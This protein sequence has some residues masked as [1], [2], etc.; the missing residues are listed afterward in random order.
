[1]KI[2]LIIITIFFVG[3]FGALALNKD[4][5][6]TQ[7]TFPQ[8][9]EGDR[10]NFVNSLNAFDKFAELTTLKNNEP[11]TLSKEQNQEALLKIEEGLNLS[12]KIDDS[13]LEY[14]SPDLKYYYREKYIKGSEIYYEGL[15]SNTGDINS[16]GVQKQIEGNKLVM[17]WINWWET[18]NKRLGEKAFP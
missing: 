3:Y 9:F 12:K 4:N 2:I 5:N 8:K 10:T 18:N 17:E 15:K 11:L 7:T 6:T 1:M 14:I 13:F 16:S